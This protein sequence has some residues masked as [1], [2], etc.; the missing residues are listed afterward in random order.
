MPPTSP[1]RRPVQGHDD[2]V[3][4]QDEASEPLSGITQ[5]PR[6]VKRLGNRR[7]GRGPS[8]ASSNPAARERGREMSMK[9]DI[10]VAVIGMGWMGQAHSR[11]YRRVPDIFHDYGVRPRLVVVADPVTSRREEAVVRFGFDHSVADWRAAIDTPGVDVVVVAT[12]NAEHAEVAIA[13]ASAGKHVFCEKPVGR[14]LA[15]TRA[16]ADA[17][18]H[19][20]V[21]GGVG[22]NYRWA[23][24]V[25]YAASLVRDG[26]LGTITHYRSRFFSMYGSNP[27]SQLS[28]RFDRD[29]A[30]LGVLGDLMPHVADMAQFLLGPIS[31][32]SATTQTHIPRRP[33]PVPGRGTHF[34]LGQADDP[35]GPVTNEDDATVPVRFASGVHGVL[36]ASR[37]IFGPKCEFGFE[38]FGTEGATRW[39]FEAMNEL[40]VYLPNMTGMSADHRHHDGFV[41]L[42]SSPDHPYHG[43]F[44]PASAAGLGYDDLKTIEAA[45][46]LHRVSS[47]TGP[48][49]TLD[50]AVAAARVAASADH[51]SRS[52]GWVTV[53]A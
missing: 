37:V 49:P 35:T 9:H 44:N 12:P 50:D 38:I 18:R 27:M 40:L 23:P 5:T 20:G 22:F 39:N 26:R 42:I 51:A 46:F 28:W 34:T 52:G 30:G 43:R 41:R 11:A 36:D 3:Q 4:T 8:E 2:P 29:A 15:E 7:R 14:T 45:E 47:G 33:I 6:Q 25:Q 13:A 32:V 17:V 24:M 53:D 10:G 1:T 21:Q 19:A 16:V 31:Q 48:G